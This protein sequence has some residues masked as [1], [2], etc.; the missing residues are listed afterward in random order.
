MVMVLEGIVMLRRLLVVG[1]FFSAVIWLNVEEV[2]FLFLEVTE[3][4][5]GELWKVF[6]MGRG[7]GQ[8]LVLELQEWIEFWR[9]LCRLLFSSVG[10]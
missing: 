5:E 1:L 7:V 10:G 3:M 9:G 4:V 6:A 2:F 8:V